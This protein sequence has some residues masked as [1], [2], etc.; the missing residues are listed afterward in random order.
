MRRDIQHYDTGY[1][2]W[3]CSVSFYAPCRGHKDF[4]SRRGDLYLT[5]TELSA[6]LDVY[7]MGRLLYICA[8]Y[9]FIFLSF[10]LGFGLGFLVVILVR[11]NVFLV[12]LSLAFDGLLILVL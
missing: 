9:L 10:G 12:L 2:V 7:R 8:L 5:S 1:R 11:L 3:L 6:D 4:Y